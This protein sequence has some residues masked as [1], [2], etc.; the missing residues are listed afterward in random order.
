MV[1]LFDYFPGFSLWQL[2]FTAIV[3]AWSGF[4]RSGLGFG[5]AALGLPFMLLVYDKPVFWIPVIG[6]HLLFFSGL[7]LSNR[8]HNV[9]WAYLLKSGKLI[10]PS[11]FAGVFGLLNLPN[12]VLLLLIYSITLVYAVMWALNRVIKSKHQWVDN[13]L[14]VFGGYVS[15]SSLTGAP[16][17]IAVFMRHVPLMKLRDTLFVLWFVIVAFKLTTLF[18]LDVPLNTVTAILLLPAAAVGHVIGLK[19]HDFL[20]ARDVLCRRLIGC[21]LILVSVAGLWELAST[22]T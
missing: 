12:A 18:M 19:T 7:T 11:A 14:L 17:M 1:W 10:L 4:V 20:L 15:G 22:G 16:L 6:S 3:F 5:G 13:L 2:A 8:L 21:L 9:D